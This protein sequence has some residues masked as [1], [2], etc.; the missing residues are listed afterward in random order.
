MAGHSGR[1]VVPMMRTRLEAAFNMQSGRYS[2]TPACT[3]RIGIERLFV[4]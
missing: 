3:R 1:V 4:C 2:W